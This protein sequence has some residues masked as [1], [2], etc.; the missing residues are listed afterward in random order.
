MSL[1]GSP[2]T[3][4]EQR[5]SSKSSVGLDDVDLS[6]D[7]FKVP[8]K[9]VA[10]DNLDVTQQMSVS[11]SINTLS[12]DD[13]TNP[14]APTNAGMDPTLSQQSGKPLVSLERVRIGHPREDV[15]V[16]PYRGLTRF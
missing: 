10:C 4:L 3:P 15:E 7:S 14:S 8:S 12:P 2:S 13:T 9:D 1:K 11:V 16:E 5:E 6:D